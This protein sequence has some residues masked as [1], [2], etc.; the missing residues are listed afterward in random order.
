VR[1]VC[2]NALVEINV[3]APG[4]LP[5][6]LELDYVRSKF[7]Q[8]ADSWNT[9]QVY[10]Y[11]SD[12]IDRRLD[13]G[14]LFLLT[15]GLSPHTIGPTAIAPAAAPSFL[16]GAERPV[17]IANANILLSNVNPIVRFHLA[18]RDKD[19]W[20]AQRVQTIQTALPTDLYYRPDWPLGSLFF[21][22][23]PNV[24]YRVEFEIETIISGGASLDTVFA[25]PPGYELAMTLTLAELLLSPFEKPPSPMLVAAASQARRNIQGLN[26]APPRINL[27]DFG[28][29][30]SERP[31]ASFNYRTGLDR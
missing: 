20:A 15:P 29:M 31:R 2:T 30:S 7:N 9:Q 6:P 17:R 1:N 18:M 28:A 19:W 23:V 3:V 24:A 4:E 26:A 25:A 10:I 16:V 21:W 14:A 8:L 11:A 27:N 12:L 5:D 13:T 22:P